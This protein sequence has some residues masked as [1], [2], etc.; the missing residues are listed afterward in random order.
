M[1]T[2]HTKIISDRDIQKKS[3]QSDCY[4]ID[5]KKG[6]P[7]YPREVN[8]APWNDYVTITVPAFAAEHNAYP[9]EWFSV[10]EY[11]K[12][13]VTC[14]PGGEGYDIDLSVDDKGVSLE[15]TSYEEGLVISKT[16]SVED[17]E[18]IRQALNNSCDGQAL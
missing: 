13:I 14:N 9:I 10:Y 18:I 6:V 16:L 15:I 2:R 11:K 3:S 4:T 1:I 7:F 12:K 17:T 5:I 8:D